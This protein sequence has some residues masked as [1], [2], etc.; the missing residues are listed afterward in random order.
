MTARCSWCRSRR[1][2]ASGPASP[3]RRSSRPIPTRRPP[4]LAR[5]PVSGAA[6]SRD[7]APPR[8][9]QAR[10]RSSS[11]ACATCTCGWST[12]CSPAKASRRSRRSPPTRSARRWR[13]SSRGSAAA[14]ASP[15]RRATSAARRAAAATSLTASP[16]GR[17][18][19][20]ASVLRRDRRSLRRRAVGEVV[21]MA[22]DGAAAAREAGEILHLAAV[23]SLTEVAIEE[24]RE[25]VEQNLRGSFLEEL[26]ARP[27]L[28]P[29]EVVR[30]AGAPGLR[31]LARRRRALRRAA[32]PSARA[33][34]SRRSPGR[35]RGAGPAHGR[36]PVDGPRV[37]ALLPA[38]GGDDAPER[39][40]AARARA[41]RAAAAPRH[42]RPVDLLR[43]PRRAR[44]ARSRRP[45]SSSTCCA[46]S[47]RAAIAEDIGTGTYRLLFRVLASHPEE[48]RSFYEDTV[49]AI[50]RYDDQ[51][52]TDLVGT[53]EAYLEHELQHERDR[54]GDLRPP[55]HRRVPA[56]AREG[57]HGPGPDAVRGPR[58]AGARAEG[59]PDHRARG[60]RAERVADLAATAAPPAFDGALG[61]RGSALDSP[62][63]VGRPRSSASASST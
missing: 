15:G 24:A 45:S 22:G 2:T 37:Y 30:R 51:Y 38:T 29:R 44:R 36:R 56:R 43:R 46:V 8:A 61:L 6:G 28:E 31:S 3:A 60:C 59:V 11:R 16:T 32:P 13:S 33:T 39:D 42:R 5:R 35:S 27:D 12:P 34:S 48:V 62:F 10:A 14:V 47:G 25:E 23:A 53:L 1:P 17:R 18:R 41:G 52:R 26:R 20:R 9:E 19:R 21:L 4:A 40:A 63:G 55:P 58:A 7:G 50:V 54:G 49:A 57:A